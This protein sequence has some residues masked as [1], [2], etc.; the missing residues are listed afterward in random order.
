VRLR[1]ILTNLVGNAVKFTSQANDRRSRQAA[2]TRTRSRRVSASRSRIAAPASARKRR[3]GCSAPFV[4]ADSSTT[5]R[6]RRQ[7]TR[8]GDRQTAGRNDARADRPAER[9]RP[10][11]TV[12]VRAGAAQAG[13]R[14]AHGG[15]HRR[16]PQRAARC[17]SSMTTPP[18]AKSWRTSSRLVDA[19]HGRR[20]RAE[21]C[22]R[23]NG[24]HDT[25]FDLAILDL[26]MP[27]MDGFEH[28][29]RDSRDTA[30]G[31]QAAGHALVGQCRRRSSGSPGATIDCYLTKPVRQSDLYD[32]I[33]T[34]CRSRRSGRP[35]RSRGQR[36]RRSR[37][38]PALG[39]RVLVAEDNP[40]NQMVARRHARIARG[41]LRAS[42]IT[43][44]LRSI[45]CCTSLLTSS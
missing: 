15:K 13:P 3:V 43:A 7:R 31:S 12:L 44:V 24:C 35:K 1:Q 23:S 26:H 6:F 20:E 42:P 32:A 45:A 5:R 11:H 21:A 28:G 33:A 30:L 34:G 39:G 36:R 18:T 41:R 25:T 40:V 38:A 27:G 16:A 4:Q 19:L 10:R 14:C 22:R 8:S 29:A 37:G 9:G 2:L 17:W